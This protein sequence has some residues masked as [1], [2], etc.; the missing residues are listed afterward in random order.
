LKIFNRWGQAV[1]ATEDYTRGWDGYL[2]NM[3]QPTGT[4]VWRSVCQ[5]A[6]EPEKQESGTLILVR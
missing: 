3:P 6:G 5:F 2:K 4:Y 1:F